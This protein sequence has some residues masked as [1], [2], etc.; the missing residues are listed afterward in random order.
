MGASARWQA[1]RS[2]WKP[3]LCLLGSLLLI[4]CQSE[5]TP[6]PE[7][8]SVTVAQAL[9]KNIRDWSEYTGRLEA[10]DSVSVRARVSGYLES[11]HFVEG[12]IVEAGELLFVIDERPF[13][14]VLDR[15][16]A[17]LKQSEVALALARTELARAR[18]LISSRAISQEELDTRVQAEQEAVAA[19]E[20][21]EAAR[22]QA[23]L[24]LRYTRVRAPITGRVG[25]ILVTRGNLIEGGSAG[26]TLLT[27]ITSQDPIYAIFTADERAYLSFLGEHADS[28]RRDDLSVSIRLTDG[29]AY[30]HTGRLDFIDN[31]L[32]P[33]TAT[34]LGRAVLP[35]PDH[36]LTPGLFA[37]IRI[38]GN[39]ER[40]VLLIPDS[41]IGSD[42]SQKFVY[43]VD[44]EQTVF[45]RP[46]TPGK[47][48]GRL[49]II[50][51]GLAPEDFVI[52]KGVQRVRAGTRVNPE[53][54][55][56]KDVKP[57]DGNSQP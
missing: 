8:P 46:V 31:Q 17:E 47:R 43:L 39:E 13:Q 3:G 26:S 9:Q 51:S 25:R 53:P 29:T 12:D 45:R 5:K 32:D 33:E 11:A 41:A 24:D 28:L 22:N 56:I 1:L 2:C 57:A 19:V 34:I 37:S 15:T 23:R 48:Q 16:E 30:P 55:Q 35:N 20:A 14:V 44:D 10:V 6:A 18:K 38:T 50:E 52:I 49:R 36:R 40:P 27:T 21:A 7:P 54:T 4:S 42:Q